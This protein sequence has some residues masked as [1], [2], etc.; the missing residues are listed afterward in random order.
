MTLA[1]LVPPGVVVR[2]HRGPLGPEHEDGLLPA[3]LPLVA[4][5][6][7][8]RRRE[9]ATGRRLARAALAAL[10]EAPVPLLPDALRAPRWPEGVVGSITHAD[11]LVAA[12]VV[13][14][15]P[16]LQALGIDAEPDLPLPV[17][18]V[19]VALTADEQAR[20]PD[21]ARLQ[22]SLKEAAYKAWSPWRASTC[23]P[24]DLEVLVL[25]AGTSRV[26]LPDGV[27]VDARWAR[28]DGLIVC[29]A[30]A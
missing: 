25:D 19:P 16:G 10:G 8:R 7:E 6:R 5:A 9:L 17:D 27:A 13:R 28:R 3:E 15:G 21:L 12:A 22:F 23:E 30:W 20:G 24:L 18:V 29:A 11:G 1:E 26:R 4:G 14:V 2:E